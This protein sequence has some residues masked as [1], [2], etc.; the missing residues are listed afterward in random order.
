MDG[1]GQ[2]EPLAVSVNFEHIEDQ[3]SRSEFSRF[4]FVIS[5][6]RASFSLRAAF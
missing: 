5:A 2:L 6:V 3:E 4:F 1:P